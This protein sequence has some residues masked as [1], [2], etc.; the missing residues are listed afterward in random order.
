MACLVLLE[1]H[2]SRA[3][4]LMFGLEPHWWRVANDG[5]TESVRSRLC[6]PDAW[7]ALLAQAGFETIEAVH[8]VPEVPAGPYVLIAQA[9]TAQRA[10]ALPQPSAPPRTWLIARDAAGY[11]ADLGRALGVALAALGQRVVTVI[12]APIYTRMDALCHALD[13]CD[14]SHWNRLLATLREE[15]EEPHGWIHLAGLDLA[16]ASA[17]LARAR[18]CAGI[19]RNRLYGLVADLRTA[20]DSAG[21]LGRRRACR[22]CAAAGGSGQC[23]PGAGRCA[24]RCGALGYRASGD[25]GVRRSAHP[26]ARPA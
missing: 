8:D 14:A 21:M 23:G 26:L 19:A 15:G 12:A 25:A 11:S 5:E 9:D 22:D 6:G 24:A 10:A 16:T 20:Q 2:A 18:R 3:A 7:R 4:D 17:P 1:K 13:P